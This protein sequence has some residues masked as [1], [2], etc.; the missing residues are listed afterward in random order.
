MAFLSAYFSDYVKDKNW[1][2]Q[3]QNIIE[4]IYKYKKDNKVFPQTLET[5]K[6]TNSRYN[7]IPDSSLNNFELYYKD[8]RGFPH[9]IDSRDKSA[10]PK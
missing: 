9:K 7:Y 2:K 1:L 3:H 5:I 8:R 4:N 10:T 6:I